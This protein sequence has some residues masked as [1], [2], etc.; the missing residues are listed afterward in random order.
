MRK[1]S[2]LLCAVFLVLFL[3]TI[4]VSAGLIGNSIISRSTMD[5]WVNFN[6]ID[7]DL[8]FTDN[9]RIDSWSIYAQKT[10]DVYLQVLR[11]DH[12]SIYEIIGQ[13][14]FVVNSTGAL[15]FTIAAANQIQ[16]QAGDYIGWSF[17]N[18]SVFG[19][20]STGDS[21][22]WTISANSA[23]TGVGN[24]VDFAGASGNR[25]YSIAANTTPVPEPASIFRIPTSAFKSL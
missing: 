21:V 1:F 11:F 15:N 13:N 25:E 24:S 9:G 18:P 10:G 19:F 6:M 2:P 22:D 4:P 23:I 12:D 17:T 5:T 14:Y 7:L 20:D 16:Y 8:Q 3:F